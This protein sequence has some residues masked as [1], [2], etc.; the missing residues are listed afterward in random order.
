MKSRVFPH[1]L[2][3][4]ELAPSDNPTSS[5]RPTHQPSSQPSSLPSLSPSNSPSIQPTSSPTLTPT[6]RPTGIPSN[7]PSLDPTEK[8]SSTPSSMPSSE[9]SFSPSTHP[10]ITPS[11]SPSAAPSIH[12]S[13]VPSNSPSIHPSDFPSVEPSKEPSSYPSISPTDEPSMTPSQ[14]PTDH[15]SQSPTDVPTKIPSPSPSANP[16]ASNAPSSS[17]TISMAPSL[18]IS[19]T[20]INK[21]TIVLTSPPN[22]PR[23][24]P[25]DV[26]DVAR[27]FLDEY[28]KNSLPN[29]L[30]YRGVDLTQATSK[31]RR[32]QTV[33]TIFCTG[34]VRFNL[35]ASP[36]G[37]M[38]NK[39]VNDAF[40]ESKSTFFASLK[41]SE[42][43]GLDSLLGVKTN[44][45]N[46]VQNGFNTVHLTI[47]IGCVSIVVIGVAASYVWKRNQ[48]N[49]VR[50]RLLRAAEFTRQYKGQPQLDDDCFRDITPEPIQISDDNK[51]L[52]RM[53]MRARHDRG[54]MNRA[55]EL[56]LQQSD[57]PQTYDPTNREVRFASY[58]VSESHQYY[59]DSNILNI[60][61]L[62][63]FLQ[64][65]ISSDQVQ[66][67]RLS[68][69]E[70]E[71]EVNKKSEIFFCLCTV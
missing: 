5:V 45:N 38:I 16:T 19:T 36:D 49:N 2:F 69:R 42:R 21:F 26:I 68:S 14:F 37:E 32:L 50:K 61:K 58:V 10:S 12:P 46:K 25:S 27:S 64:H 11:S 39:Y 67:Q 55:N 35:F 31:G 7:I 53:V 51:A 18:V 44:E 13:S 3:F 70:D 56:L 62:F 9:P 57:L 63:F 41:K 22:T 33:T 4:Y 28:L 20:S 17:P 23:I 71:S 34:E 52:E 8:P 30:K 15:P 65:K 60:L 24:D 54:V 59:L 43:V 48:E 40:S 66:R 6:S 29:Y 47:I 1:F